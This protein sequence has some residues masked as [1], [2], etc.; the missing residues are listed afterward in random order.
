MSPW[1]RRTGDGSSLSSLGLLARGRE[2]VDL[3]A[4]VPRGAV[5]HGARNEREQ[6]VIFADADV[7]AGDQPGAALAHE[8]RAGVDV[9][10]RVLLYAV[11]LPGGI[12]TVAGRTRA[13]LVG[14]PYVS[15]FEML[16]VVVFD[17]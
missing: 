4:V 3:A 11:P 1:P 14:H 17:W 2:D 12:A 10:A 15:I 13:F 9:A 8:D 6:R 7:L 5:L 16:K